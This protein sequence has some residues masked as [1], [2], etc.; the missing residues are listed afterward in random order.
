[1][2][3]YKLTGPSLL[4][5]SSVQKSTRSM[6]AAD[7]GLRIINFLLSVIFRR[8]TFS[9][10]WLSFSYFSHLV[11]IF[12]SRVLF[13]CPFTGHW[14]VVILWFILCPTVCFVYHSV[15]FIFEFLSLFLAVSCDVSFDIH[16]CIHCVHT[17]WVLFSYSK[18]VCFRI[19]KVLS[20]VDPVHW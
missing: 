12:F 5:T 4:V 3:S 18:G 13:Q 10:D 2:F 19:L 9:F 8:S 20:L 14:L 16:R 1:M 15:G 6:K 11:V 7:I 17:Q